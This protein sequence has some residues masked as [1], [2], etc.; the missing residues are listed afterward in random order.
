M[1]RS[2]QPEDPLLYQNV[3]PK[4]D[5]KYKKDGNDRKKDTKDDERSKKGQGAVLKPAPKPAPKQRKEKPPRPT[6]EEYAPVKKKWEQQ[7]WKMLEFGF[8]VTRKNTAWTEDWEEHDNHPWFRKAKQGQEQRKGGARGL[9]K[10][11]SNSPPSKRHRIDPQ[12]DL[13]MQDP[14]SPEG[15]LETLRLWGRGAER[16]PRLRC[17]NDGARDQNGSVE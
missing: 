11:E 16:V 10:T 9:L 6:V 4:E 12:D 15:V 13:S 1:R 8:W 5:Q 7:G 17:S 14:H 3:P 2:E